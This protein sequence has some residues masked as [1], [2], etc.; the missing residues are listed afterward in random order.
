M[1]NN[2]DYKE[3]IT[4]DIVFYT[5]IGWSIF[6]FVNSLLFFLLPLILLYSLLFDRDK[7]IFAYIIKLFYYIFYFLNFTQ[8]TDIDKNGLKIPKRGERRI[9]VLNHASMFDVILMFLLPGPIK[10]LMKESYTKIPVIGWIAVLAGNITMKFNQNSGD[11]LDIYMSIVEKLERGSCIV[12][13]PE[14]TKS[15]DSKMGKFHNGTFKIAIDTKSDLV[16]VVFDTWNVI[17]PGGLWIRDVKPTIR[18]LDTVKYDEIKEMKYKEISK[19]IRIKILEGLINVRDERR[20]NDKK[21]YRNNEKYIKLDNEMKEE[22][23]IL[24]NESIK[25]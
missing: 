13:Y 11:F 18:I 10:S 5:I 21:Y 2:T 7:K 23:N 1:N 15:K 6:V 9:Y 17:R 24:K 12:L 19:I 22:L 25:N 3:K 8:K 16:P 20:K 14:G 4:I